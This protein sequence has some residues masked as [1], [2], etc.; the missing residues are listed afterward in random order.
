ME[1]SKNMGSNSVNLI[2]VNQK[3]YR[4]K[5]FFNIEHHYCE[6]Y[7]IAVSLTKESYIKIQ[8]YTRKPFEK[9]K[10]NKKY[11]KLYFNTANQVRKEVMNSIG[12]ALTQLNYDQ[13]KIGPVPSSRCK[14]CK[15][16]CPVDISEAI[17][18]YC[19]QRRQ[20]KCDSEMEEKDHIWFRTDIKQGIVECS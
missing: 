8:F 3:I 5:V 2:L 7:E 20:R 18:I 12:K 1:G 15:I 17:E 4:N 10:N 16:V 9:W 14:D 11:R 6:E 19:P 13:D